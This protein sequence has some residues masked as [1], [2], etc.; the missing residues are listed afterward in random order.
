MKISKY[1]YMALNLRSRGWRELSPPSTT[2]AFSTSAIHLIIQKTTFS[3]DMRTLI[4]ALP[5]CFTLTLHMLELH[6]KSALIYK[7]YRVGFTHV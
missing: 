3:C 2:S 6:V 5:K 4:S 7:L 1:R